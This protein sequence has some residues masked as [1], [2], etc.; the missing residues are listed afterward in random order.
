MELTPFIFVAVFLTS[1][2]PNLV[3]AGD[4]IANETIPAWISDGC[5]PY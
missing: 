3:V 4:E 2:N 5:V 1:S